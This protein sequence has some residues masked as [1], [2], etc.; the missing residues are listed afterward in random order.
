MPQNNVHKFLVKFPGDQNAS[1][2]ELIP[3]SADIKPL[4]P[5]LN[6]VVYPPYVTK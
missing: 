4:L 3:L 5:S 1:V 6:V 2:P